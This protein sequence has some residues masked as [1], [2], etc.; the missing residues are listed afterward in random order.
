MYALTII[1]PEKNLFSMQDVV[2]PVVYFF[3]QN[4]TIFGP[5]LLC[6]KTSHWQKVNVLIFWPLIGAENWTQKCINNDRIF[7]DALRC[8]SQL[9]RSSRFTE[10]G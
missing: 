2:I 8:L 9:S 7:D 3:S 5:C 10:A 4:Y 1:K 6:K